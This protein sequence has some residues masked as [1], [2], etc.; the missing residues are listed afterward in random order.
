MDIRNIIGHEK[1]K[2]YIAGSMKENRL[3]HGYLFSGPNGIGKRL[4]SLGVSKTI[5]CK[6]SDVL[7]CGNCSACH[8]FDSLN[9]PDIMI[10]EADGN[11]IKNKQVEDIQNFIKIKPNESEKKI[12]IIDDADKMTVSAQN[13]ILKTLEE[14]PSYGMIFLISSKPHSLLPTI[15]SR[16]QILDFGKIEDELIEKYL[17]DKQDVSAENAKLIS[18]FADG[19]LR[20]AT[21]IVVSEKFK[22]HREQV[23]K[24]SDVLIK[25]ELM[26]VYD[27]LIEIG[28]QKEDI[29][30]ILDLLN[31]WF[32]DLMF[33]KSFNSVDMIFNL[34]FEK[35]LR[36]QSRL[37][38]QNNTLIYMEMIENTK[39]KIASNVN[40]T[41]A[42]ESCV[43]N[44]QEV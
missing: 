8:K 24:L 40:C 23:V 34:D 38:N 3:S 30:E 11:S 2:T 17:I 36:E 1:I 10:I 9:H 13:R 29:N 26:K 25:K 35:E 14:P 41:L 20:I 21:D 33:L 39:K 27:L 18:K 43:L 4:L 42:L 6:E 12:I 32:R 15:K 16:C 5:F 37:L 7:A 22:E 19:S 31:V 28:D 44:I